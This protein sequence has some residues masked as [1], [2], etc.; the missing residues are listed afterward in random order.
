MPIQ[1]TIFLPFARMHIGL[2][3]MGLH[4]SLLDDGVMDLV[5]VLSC[6]F[7]PI[8]YRAFIPSIGVHNGLDG[9]SIGKQITTITTNSVGVRSPPSS[10]LVVRYMSSDRCGSDSVGDDTS[11]YG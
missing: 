5:A 8:R 10:C 3:V 1:T 6:S 7:L 2:H 4:L 11:E 9:T